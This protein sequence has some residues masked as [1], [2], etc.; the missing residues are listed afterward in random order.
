MP[1]GMF[2]EHKRGVLVQ[3]NQL[4]VHYLVCLLVLEHTVL[5]D[6][7]RHQ[8]QLQL[9]RTFDVLRYSIS[10]QLGKH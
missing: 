7:A 1:A 6:R 5:H 10:R 2:A 4:S 9:H 3:P 8:E